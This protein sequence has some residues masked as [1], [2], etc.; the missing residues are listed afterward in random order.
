VVQL[1]IEAD[2]P[3]EEQMTEEIPLTTNGKKGEERCK[4]LLDHV[5]QGHFPTE[6]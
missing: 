6:I 4:I 5:V 3:N 2:F 1:I